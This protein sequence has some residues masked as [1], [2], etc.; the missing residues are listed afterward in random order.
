MTPIFEYRH[1]VH[2]DDIDELGHANNLSYLRWAL[3]AAVAHSDV[4]GWP[5]EAYR[6]LGA[7]WVVRSHQ[8]EYLQPAFDGDAVIVRTWV[9]DMK[10]VTSLRQFRIVRNVGGKEVLLARAAT[11]WA[12]IHFAT[13]APKRIPPEVSSAFQVVTDQ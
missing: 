12:F 13:G 7:G 3:A 2:R 8:I 9:A 10:K 1:T 4:E 6:A 11:D 5:A